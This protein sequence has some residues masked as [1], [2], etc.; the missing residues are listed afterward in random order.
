[1]Q[2]EVY[3]GL[4]MAIF[5]GFLWLWTRGPGGGTGLPVQAPGWEKLLSKIVDYGICLS[6]AAILLTGFAKAY[7]A[8]TDR[9]VNA[10]AERIL[11]MTA[12]FSFARD[13]HE[14]AAGLLGWWFGAHFAAALWHWF[15]RRDGVM[16]AISVRKAT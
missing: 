16:R 5:Y 9:V 6:I 7:L 13:A 1:M 14:F 8:P 10:A 15:V 3:V 12:R 11:D 2:F 4:A